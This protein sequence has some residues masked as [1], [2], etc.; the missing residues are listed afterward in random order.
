[1]DGGVV[2]RV[3]ALQRRYRRWME[4]G[5]SRARRTVVVVVVVMALTY[6]RASGEQPGVR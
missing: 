3:L 1:M 5:E 2:A 6:R 4:V